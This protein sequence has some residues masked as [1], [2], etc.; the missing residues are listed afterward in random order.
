MNLYKVV[1]SHHSPKDSQKGIKTLLLAENS[2]QVYEWIK[3]EPKMEDRSLFNT[4][5]DSEKDEEVFEI[6]NDKWEVIGTEN[7]K[8]KMLRINGEINDD[9]YDFSDS[10]YGRTL[11]GWEVIKENTTNDYSELIDAGIV[12]SAISK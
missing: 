9:D 1:F 6:Y 3:S 5:A 8:E 10:Y 7:F 4:W 11:Y 12:R 2:E